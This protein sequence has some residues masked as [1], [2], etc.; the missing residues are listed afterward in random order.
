MEITAENIHKAAAQV[1]TRTKTD[2]VLL[3]ALSA[4]RDGSLS[5][6]RN[7]QAD[8]R[9]KATKGGFLV[10]A[11]NEAARLVPA[12]LLHEEACRAIE[13][14]LAYHE[15]LNEAGRKAVGIK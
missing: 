1:V 4:A 12:A 5:W 3:L 13:T 8:L 11:M 6:A 15:K 2:S 10:S 14:I 9:V 7:F